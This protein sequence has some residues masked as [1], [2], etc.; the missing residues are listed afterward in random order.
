MEEKKKRK[1]WV[2]PKIMNWQPW[3]ENVLDLHIAGMSGAEIA[4]KLKRFPETIRRIIRSD[5]FQQKL[6]EYHEIKVKR[7]VDGIKLIVSWELDLLKILKSICE[8]PKAPASARKDAASWLLERLP[9]YKYVKE[10]HTVN[11]YQP[12]K[13]DTA[14]MAET[15]EKM[16]KVV[17][18]LRRGNEFVLGEGDKKS[19]AEKLDENKSP[20]NSIDE[21]RDTQ[22]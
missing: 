19:V 11:V 18:F 7:R 12:T 1:K 15:A 17:E 22:A 2:P 21:R 6:N 13:E 16:K 5:I 10:Q 4:R 14:R 3:Y 8:D 20:K 9:E